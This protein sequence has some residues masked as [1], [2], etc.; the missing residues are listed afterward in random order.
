MCIS[1]CI[2]IFEFISTEGTS[3]HPFPRQKKKTQ[4]KNKEIEKT[5]PK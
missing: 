3:D 1:E 5:P 4:Q 2:F